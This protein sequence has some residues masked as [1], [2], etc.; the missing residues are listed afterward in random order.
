MEDCNNITYRKIHRT[1]SLNDITKDSSVLFDTTMISLPNTSLNS[2]Q[3][4][5]DLNDKIKLLSDDLLIAHQE[6]ENLISE[7]FQL[8][9]DL[10]KY[11]K[12]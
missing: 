8:K 10:Q 11:L 6:I 9:S 12:V 1:S 4:V 5:I 3:T 2:S 7:N